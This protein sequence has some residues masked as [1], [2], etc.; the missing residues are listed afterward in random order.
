MSTPLEDLFRHNLW[1][2]LQILD[3]CATLTDEQ[4]DAVVTGTF[5][6]IRDTLN[7]MISSEAAYAARLMGQ[8]P[9]LDASSLSGFD[10]LKAAAKQSG[11]ALRT[12]AAGNPATEVL[13]YRSMGGDPVE[14][15]NAV[16]LVQSINHA[17][18]HRDQIN[19]V[20]TH[21]N[22][23]TKELDGWAYGMESG[24]FK[25]EEKQAAND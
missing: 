11:E 13:K 7:H 9:T 18:E 4:L 8:R 2:N 6:S 15:T 5:G 22:V 16:L 10:D 19:S 1:A 24:Q 20:L 14:T 12:I 21:L 25:I 17:T 23:E 3:I